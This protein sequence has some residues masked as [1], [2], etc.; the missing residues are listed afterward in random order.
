MVIIVS[1][2]VLMKTSIRIHFDFLLQKF[3]LAITCRPIMSENF[4]DEPFPFDF[5]GL[6]MV[7]LFTYKY[8][9]YNRSILVA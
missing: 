9:M 3:G 1:L 8:N 7:L 6:I 5:C 4:N 2:A